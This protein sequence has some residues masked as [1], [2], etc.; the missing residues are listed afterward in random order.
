MILKPSP[1]TPDM[2]SNGDNDGTHRRQGCS[3][4]LDDS[5]DSDEWHPGMLFAKA[6]DGLPYGQ[7]PIIA[8]CT[9][10]GANNGPGLAY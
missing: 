6:K 2:V 3:D 7:M 9:G 5:D 1:Q 8:P 4:A 10:A